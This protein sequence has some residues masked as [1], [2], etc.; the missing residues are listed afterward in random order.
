[1]HELTIINHC[2]GAI[3]LR[4]FGL[5]PHYSPC[6]ALKQLQNLLE[7]NTKWAKNRKIEQIKQTLKNSDVIVSAW[8]NNKIVGFGRASSDH[9]F[10]ATLWDVVIRQDEQRN[11]LGKII[12]TQLLK[13]KKLKNVEKIY[14]MTSQSANFYEQL[15]FK[16]NINQTLMVINNSLN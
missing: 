5:G 9:V 7:E 13:S 12:V 15:G 4:L 1:M 3:G 10:R 14:L 16:K 11:G 8:K 6:K 2:P